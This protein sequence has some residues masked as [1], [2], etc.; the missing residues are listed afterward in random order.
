M[1]KKLGMALALMYVIGTWVYGVVYIWNHWA[2]A[3]HYGVLAWY[4]FIRALI[5]PV[6]LLL[7]LF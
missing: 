3:E 5:W 6:W 1:R 4:A 7:E 2:G